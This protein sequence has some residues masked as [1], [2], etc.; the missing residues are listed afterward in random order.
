MKSLVIILNYNSPRDTLRLSAQILDK[1]SLPICIIDNKSTD[2]SVDLISNFC[3]ENERLKLIE[4]PVNGGF[5]AGNNIG[6]HYAIDSGFSTAFIINPDVYIQDGSAF[7]VCL[8]VLKS[9]D[10]A[11][12]VGPKIND[13]DPY[14]IRPNLLS[15]ILPPAHRLF[16]R[17]YC[18]T[19]REYDLEAD[20]VYRLYGCFWCVDLL[21][22]ARLDFFDDDAFLYFEEN[23]LA[24]KALNNN[25]SFYYVQSVSIDH[26][27]QGSVTQLGIKQFKYFFKSCFLYL[28]RYR[29]YP[30]LVAY[31]LS[32]I[33]VFFRIIINLSRAKLG[34]RIF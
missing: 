24:E 11:L 2:N 7:D 20:V 3:K 29:G 26:G 21:K 13:V 19:Q 1:T 16:E 15:F 34:S 9:N 30:R 6:L 10:S 25:L 17:F 22:M 32:F 27:L 28:N 14:P 33:D 8:N 31:I 4:S 23:I 18:K 5:S 12:A